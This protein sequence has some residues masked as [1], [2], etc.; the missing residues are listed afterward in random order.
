MPSLLINRI[1]AVLITALPIVDI[2]ADSSNQGYWAGN[3]ILYP[4][5]PVYCGKDPLVDKASPCYGSPGDQYLLPKSAPLPPTEEQCKYVEGVNNWYKWKP[6]TVPKEKQ[7]FYGYR[8]C[9]LED[10]GEP[11]DINDFN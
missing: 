6:R 4:Y 8:I 10:R 11:K 7:K 1:I 3:A 9:Y 2:S 5:K